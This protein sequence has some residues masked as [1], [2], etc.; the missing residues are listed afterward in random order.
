MLSRDADGRSYWLMWV[1]MILL[2]WGEVGGDVVF[3]ECISKTVWF[4]EEMEVSR[5][6]HAHRES[7]KR[8][9]STEE[10]NHGEKR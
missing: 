6:R 8:T 1:T 5:L 10:K 2:S 9:T 7:G 4:E 3:G